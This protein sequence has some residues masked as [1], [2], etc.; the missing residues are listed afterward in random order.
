MFAEN[1][2]TDH[3]GASAVQALAALMGVVVMFGS[4]RAEPPEPMGDSPAV[5]PLVGAV[6][7]SSNNIFDLDEP[8]EDRAAYRLANKLHVTTRPEVIRQQLLF[9]PGEPFSKQAIE[10]SERILRSNRYIQEASIQPVL[11]DDGVVDITVTTSDVW[12]LMPKLSFSQAGGATNTAV[13]V[14]EMNLLGTGVAVEA[15][16]KSDID[17]D[18]KVFKIVDHNLGQSW[19]GIATSIADNS[20]GHEYAFDLGKPFYSLNS[21]DARMLSVLDMDRIEPVYVDGEAASEFRLKSRGLEFFF[22]RST[23]LEDGWARRITYG[24]VV[25]EQLY[26]ANENTDPSLLPDFDNR[27]LVYP[28]IG[29]DFVEDN[30]AKASNFDQIHRVEDRFLGTRV[31]AR[32]GVAGRAFGSDRD[33]LVFDAMAQ[34]GFG[35]TAK[36]SLMLTTSL[37]SRVE[38]DGPHNL[39]FGVNAKFYRRQSERRLLYME[40]AGTYGHNL[41]LD[42]YQP[43]GGD[44][45]MRGY[46]VRF[47]NGDK[48]AVFT[49]EQRLFTNWYP[50]RLFY[51]GGAAFFDIGRTWGEGPLTDA[52]DRLLKDVGVGLRLGGTRSGLGRMIHIDVAFPL[53]AP[54]GI[55]NVQFLVSTR[56]SF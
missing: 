40:L 20:D 43:L 36:N 18:S 48:H 19:Y 16:Y 42:Q 4:V 27:N 34:K 1:N 50:F 11:Q 14:K 35:D 51:V 32:V 37:A 26:T 39:Q 30:F 21:T 5:A 41:D 25:D 2:N 46:P 12:T 8:E 13:G 6:L 9:E 17:R 55:D 54:E 22:G 53:D 49:V 29:I 47:Q 52:N 44:N 10:E 28:F 15:M 3:A 38:R 33:A 7:I 45:G 31:T 56:K 23:G 24:L